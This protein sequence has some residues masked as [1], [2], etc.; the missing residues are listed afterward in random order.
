MHT[1]KAFELVVL[2][3][4]VGACDAVSSTPA[5]GTSG[6]VAPSAAPDP[7][8]TVTVEL[9]TMGNGPNS[10]NFVAGSVGTATVNGASVLCD[11]ST[12]LGLDD[13]V[14]FQACAGSIVSVG[15]VGGLGDITTAPSGGSGKSAAATINAGYVVKTVEGN[16]YRVFVQHNIVD[17]N[18]SVLGV[19]LKWA[20]LGEECA[21]MLTRCNGVCVNTETDI[22]NCGGCGIV[23]PGGADAGAGCQTGSTGTGVCTMPVRTR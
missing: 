17:A 13:A 23:C 8:G 18:R 19:A 11:G 3:A 4:V 6:S 22:T 21:G 20:P 14:N 2:L 7:P 15:A 5:M 12:Q 10:L 16:T 9:R 1:L